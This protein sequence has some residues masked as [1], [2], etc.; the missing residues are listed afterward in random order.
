MQFQICLLV[1]YCFDMNVARLHD[2]VEQPQVLAAG[3]R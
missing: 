3:V 2:Q 1:W